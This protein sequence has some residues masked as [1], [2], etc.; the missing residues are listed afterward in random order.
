MHGALE[1]PGLVTGVLSERLD[2]TGLESKIS[3]VLIDEHMVLISPNDPSAG[4]NVGHAMALHD[5]SHA[6]WNSL[7]RSRALVVSVA[8]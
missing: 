2:Q 5:T 4:F 7:A 1:S 6:R 3:P 8:R